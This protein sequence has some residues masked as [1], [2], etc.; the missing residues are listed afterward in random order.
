MRSCGA[1]GSGSTV[2]T[3]LIFS[4]STDPLRPFRFCSTDATTVRYIQMFS[5]VLLVTFRTGRSAVPSTYPFFSIK[6]V[7]RYFFLGENKQPLL[8]VQRRGLLLLLRA[9]NEDFL[10]YVFWHDSVS[11]NLLR[12]KGIRNNNGTSFFYVRRTVCS[13]LTLQDNG[14]AKNCDLLAQ[15]FC[16]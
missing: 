4:R 12:N 15:Y 6:I 13:H 10:Q 8:V 11:V 16:A 14:V 5:T 2:S 3:H 1:L 9:L 7:V